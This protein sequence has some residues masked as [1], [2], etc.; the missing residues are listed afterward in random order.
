MKNSKLLSIAVSKVI[1]PSAFPVVRFVK[2][3]IF[4][5]H[6]DRGNLKPSIFGWPF[7]LWARAWG[8]MTHYVRREFNDYAC[9][10]YFHFHQHH[11]GPTG[12]GYFSYADLDRTAKAN[13]FGQPAGRVAPFIERYADLLGYADGNSFLDA[14]CGRGQNIKVL[15]DRF[16]SSVIHGID[17]N[18]EAA[19]VITLA[20]DDHRVMVCPGDLTDPE[21]IRAI[22]NN[23][24]DHVVLSHVLSI[25][26]GD[27]RE[28]TLKIRSMI[29]TELARVASK[30]LLII[31]SH[32]II[33]DR[34][35]FEIEQ[36]DRGA[37]VESILPYFEPLPGRTMVFSAAGSVAVLYQPT[38]PSC[39]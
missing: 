1:V 23:A 24:Y 22:G 37:Y 34:V 7:I 31:D 15:M 11:Y 12:R 39:P 27:G 8:Y 38:Q 13:L 18:A 5:A 3:Q 32:A 36:R 10:K 29:I 33:S 19:E 17:F 30:S 26:I 16:P 20:V 28:A 9:R 35:Q 14:G 6:F 4:L 25:I 21:T 2:D